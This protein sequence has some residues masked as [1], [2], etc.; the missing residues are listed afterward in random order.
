MQEI[1]YNDQN[2]KKQ[3]LMRNEIAVIDLLLFDTKFETL[4]D[5]G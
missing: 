1:N 5:N 2:S 4:L 3:T